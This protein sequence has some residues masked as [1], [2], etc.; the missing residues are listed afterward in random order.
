MVD[1]SGRIVLVTGAG[2]GL[3]AAYAELLA[4]SGAH[5]IVHDAGVERNGKGGDP[6]VAAGVTHR[7]VRAGGSAEPAT[8]NLDTVDGCT[9]LVTEAVARHGRID[10][11]VHNA[12]IVRYSGIADTTPQEWSRMLAVNVQAAWWLC[13]AVWPTMVDQRYGR[14]VLTTSGL[15]LRPI[16]GADVTGYSVTKAAQVG[17]MNGLAA[18]GEPHG[19]RVNCVSPLAATRIFRRPVEKGQMTAS[20][21]APG[22]VM[23]ASTSSIQAKRR[24]NGAPLF[25]GSG[26]ALTPA[27]VVASA[28]F[29]S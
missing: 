26:S 1:M 20:S 24:C 2:R 13:R 28:L 16:P 17:L 10:A 4:A 15:S 12:G 21:V 3:G 7:I 6:S 22:V 27:A 25:P 8:Q 14:I 5:V 18:E 23:L 11:L 9:A 19:I 29:F